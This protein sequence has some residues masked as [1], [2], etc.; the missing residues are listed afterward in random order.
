MLV[1]QQGLVVAVEIRR[2]INDN[3]LMGK[4]LASIRDT[5][6]CTRRPLLLL[7]EV[8]KRLTVGQVQHQEALVGTGRQ[9][10]RIGYHHL[11]VL[12]TVRIVVDH[13]IEQVPSW[14]LLLH[15][16]LKTV[17]LVVELTHRNLQLR[18]LLTQ[19]ENECPELHLRFG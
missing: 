2:K 17:D 8:L 14:R 10:P 16:D 4:G 12:K 6:G 1:L 18:T 13:Y 11:R 19:R 3:P 15:I 5:L 7:V 9:T